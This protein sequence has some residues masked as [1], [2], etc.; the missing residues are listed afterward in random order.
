MRTEAPRF[1]TMR[2]WRMIGTS[3][4]TKP[5]PRLDADAASA[6]RTTMSAGRRR[7]RRVPVTLRGPHRGRAAAGER[8][9]RSG[10]QTARSPG[11]LRVARCG[12][13]DAGRI[14]PPHRHAELRVPAPYR[15]DRRGPCVR[16]VPHRQYAL[17]EPA[18]RD[19][20]V[21]ESLDAPLQN[22]DRFRAAPL[23]SQHL[24]ELFV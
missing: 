6:S 16:G 9:G 19:R 12:G 23:D 10:G 21:G 17:D 15:L 22:G 24:A 7:Y 2:F 1:W 20:A 8:E 3:S 5:L 4:Y 11:S 13:G 14:E 18:S